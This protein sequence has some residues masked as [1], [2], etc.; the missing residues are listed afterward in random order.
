MTENI[1]TNDRFTVTSPRRGRLLGLGH[2]MGHGRPWRSLAAL[3]LMAMAM[4]AV[5]V[6]AGGAVQNVD[7]VAHAVT[8]NL[9]WGPVLINGASGTVAESSPTLANLAGGPAVVFG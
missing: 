7:V 8:S 6:P 2:W 1:A 5:A 9:V 3:G 4:T